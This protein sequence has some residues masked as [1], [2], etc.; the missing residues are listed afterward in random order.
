MTFKNSDNDNQS[1]I[2]IINRTDESIE[3]DFTCVV[4]SENIEVEKQRI[5]CENIDPEGM[6]SMDLFDPS[7]EYNPGQV[8]DGE[9]NIGVIRIFVP[10][11]EE[12]TEIGYIGLEI[13]DGD[14]NEKVKYK[15]ILK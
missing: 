7:G 8:Y 14:S 9:T 1:E 10:Y 15:A 3:I 13:L 11:E 2:N 4:K 6:N 12:D 5:T